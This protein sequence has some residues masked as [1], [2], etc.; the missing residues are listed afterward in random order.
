MGINYTYSVEKSA[1]HS[2][3]ASSWNAL[4][5]SFY[6]KFRS[7][8]KTKGTFLLDWGLACVDEQTEWVRVQD[9]HEVHNSSEKKEG[10]KQNKNKGLLECRSQ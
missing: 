10:E 6:F 9:S 2:F 5:T 3:P 4:Q 8:E 7:K 1:D